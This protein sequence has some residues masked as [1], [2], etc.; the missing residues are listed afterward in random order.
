MQPTTT[1]PQKVVRK[2]PAKIDIAEEIKQAHRQL[3]VAAYCRVSTAQEEQ[4]NSYDVQVMPYS[5]LHFR[6][7]RDAGQ[8]RQHPGEQ[9]CTAHHQPVHL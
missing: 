9:G 7:P 4:L 5:S 2:I 3:R 1:T 8:E 6:K